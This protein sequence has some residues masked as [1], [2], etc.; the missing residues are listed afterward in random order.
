MIAEGAQ[1]IDVGDRPGQCSQYLAL[2][3]R[4][5]A[6]QQRTGRCI[7]D[8]L[9]R[10]G[11]VGRD[12]FGNAEGIDV[13]DH[14]PHLIT[15]LGLAQGEGAVGGARDVDELHAVGGL[16]L[17]GELRITDAIGIDDA[18]WV[19]AQH[20][21]LHQQTR[22]GRSCGRRAVGRRVD[23]FQGALGILIHRPH[24]DVRARHIVRHPVGG[25]GCPRGLARSD[26]GD[27]FIDP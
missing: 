19:S 13:T 4:G 23:D 12:A 17:V 3:R 24:A 27:V 10:I 21:V 7:V 26:K 6:D 15:D 5:V 9:D 22:D 25:A 20:L 8:V 16:P 18:R 2:I 1:A 14:H 11:R